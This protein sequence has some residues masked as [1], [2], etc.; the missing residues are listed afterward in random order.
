MT[1]PFSSFMQRALFDPKGGYYT[2]RI[3]TV[4]ARGDFST[5]ATL[6]PLLG[7][8][9]AGWLLAEAKATGVRTIIEVGGGDGSLMQAVLK[10]L[11]WWRRWRFRVLMVDASPVLVAQQKQRLGSRVEAWFGTLPEALNACNGE[12]LIF[13]NELLDAFPVDL[14]Q[15]DGTS[16]QEVWLNHDNGV[17]REELRPLSLDPKPHSALQTQGTGRRELHTA[18]HE[19]LEQWLPKWQRGAMLTIDYG[20]VFPALYHR[21][22]HG[23]LRAYLMQQRLTGPEV[24]QNPGRQDITCDVNFTDYRAWLAAADTQEMAFETQ[25]EFIRRHISAPKDG[26]DAFVCDEQG[27]GQAFKCLSV[28]RAIAAFSCRQDL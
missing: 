10:S 28:R 4:G 9:I 15:G 20:D 26:R 21:R 11:G 24:Y 5:S 22:P 2:A 23:T 3:K 1:E 16:W 14:V 17:T 7:R 18:V 27:A 25:A 6:S 8:A 19:W 13:H 12:A